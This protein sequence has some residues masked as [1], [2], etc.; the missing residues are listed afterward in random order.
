MNFE[1]IVHITGQL[2][3]QIRDMPPEARITI[4]AA[5]WQV[6]PAVTPAPREQDEADYLLTCAWDDMAGTSAPYELAQGR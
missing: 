5:A 3:Q 4:L 6:T 1:V 2:H